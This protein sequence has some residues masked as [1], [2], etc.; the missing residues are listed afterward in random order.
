M[1]EKQKLL[2]PL[3]ATMLAH[4]QRQE[5]NGLFYVADLKTVNNADPGFWVCD[6]SRA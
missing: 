3:C 1:P 2:A 5:L 4:V 6:I